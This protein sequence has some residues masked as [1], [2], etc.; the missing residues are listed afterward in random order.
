MSIQIKKNGFFQNILYA[1][2]AQGISMI[3][4]ILMSLFLPKVLGVREQC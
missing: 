1:F 4:S 2:G 3:L